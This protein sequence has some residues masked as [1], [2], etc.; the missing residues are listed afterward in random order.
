VGKLDA[1]IIIPLDFFEKLISKFEGDPELGVG[2]GVSYSPNTECNLNR[3][4][5]IKEECF[6]RDYYIPGELP[7]KRLYRR[8]QLD[9]VGGFP[10]SKFSPDTVLLS[11]FRINGWKIKSFDDIKIYNLRTDSG[12]ERNL[13]KSSKLLGCGRYYLNYH[14]LFILLTAI[15][16]LTCRPLS[17]SIGYILGYTSSLIK[18]K[19]QIHDPELRHY[20]KY[21]RPLEIFFSLCKSLNK[22]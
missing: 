16:F 19:E 18:G 21:K 15:Y 8:S 13:W 3:C 12:T 10:Q 4:C 7:D 20:F 22:S 1:D 5:D 17:F 2:S 9:E 11:K 6:S 14:P